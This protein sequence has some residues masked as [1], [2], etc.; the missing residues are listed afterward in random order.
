MTIPVPSKEKTIIT[1]P[2]PVPKRHMSANIDGYKATLMRH[3]DARAN[4]IMQPNEI[5]PRIVHAM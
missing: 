3:T 2:P 1:T 5:K 4:E